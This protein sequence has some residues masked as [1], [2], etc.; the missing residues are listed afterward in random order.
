M[1]RLWYRFDLSHKFTAIQASVQEKLSNC[2]FKKQLE[3]KFG[4]TTCYSQSC[5]LSPSAAVGP[6]RLVVILTYETHY[7]SDDLCW[8]RRLQTTQLQWWNEVVIQYLKK[9][10]KKKQGFIVSAGGGVCA[11]CCCMPIGNTISDRAPCCLLKMY[12]HYK[13]HLCVAVRDWHR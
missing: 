2:V 7:P 3:S 9:K 10:Q 8:H 1:F 11:N 13:E 12:W 5:V 6:R 4:E